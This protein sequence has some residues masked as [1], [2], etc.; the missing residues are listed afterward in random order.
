MG[1]KEEIFEQPTVLR[2][3]LEKQKSQIEAIAKE[4]RK[5]D[6]DYV[7]LTARGTSDNAGLYAK[8]L[9]GIANELPVAL[10]AP[11]LFSIYQKP[12]KLKNSLVLGISQSGQSPDIVSVIE[13]GKR[14]GVPT[15]SITNDVDSPLARGSEFVIDISAGV[16]SAVAATK[17]YTAELMAIAMLSASLGQDTT[18]LGVLQKVPGYIEQVLELDSIIARVAERFTFMDH[19]VV[20]GRGY[21][22]STAFEW[23]L[24]IK[25]LTYVVAEPYSSADFRHGPIA[26]VDQGFAVM[27]VIASGSIENDMVSLV[28]RLKHEKRADLLVISNQNDALE[29]AENAFAFDPEVEEW[30]SPIVSVVPAQLFCYYLTRNKGLDPEE[31]RGLM[32]VTE[33]R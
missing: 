6:I 32:K 11:S 19:C 22:Y 10:A 26:V 21:N 3:L 20:L 31:P 17:T 16:E 15:L 30:I 18:R 28:R 7:F 9:F 1:L 12:P 33:T 13:E 24:K 8:Y 2:G 14:Q 27:A 25:E 5:R 23:S 29:I 4:I